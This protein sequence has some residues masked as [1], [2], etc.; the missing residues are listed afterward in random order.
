MQIT[1]ITI[2]A[3]F[4]MGNKSASWKFACIP[5]RISILSSLSPGQARLNTITVHYLN[6]VKII[7]PIA[8]NKEGSPLMLTSRMKLRDSFSA[9]KQ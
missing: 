5:G 1:L 3:R 6:D 7:L 8:F 2:N 4:K 9:I